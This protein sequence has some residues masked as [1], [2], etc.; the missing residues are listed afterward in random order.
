MYGLKGF[1][2]LQ[3]DQMQEELEHASVLMQL[4][5]LRHGRVNLQAI[6][7]PQPQH[8]SSPLEAVKTTLQIETVTATVR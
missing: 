1:V 2:K 6:E 5:H 8:W 7:P 4:M 3:K